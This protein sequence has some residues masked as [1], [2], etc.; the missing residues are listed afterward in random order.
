M[1]LRLVPR[2]FPFPDADPDRRLQILVMVAF[3][4]LFDQLSGRLVGKTFRQPP[5][6]RPLDLNI[7]S[8]PHFISGQDIKDRQLVVFEFL[9]VDW[10]QVLNGDDRNR[11]PDHQENRM[12]GNTEHCTRE[13]SGRSLY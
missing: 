13:R 12:K 11:G 10:I 5:R 2:Q 3:A 1:V 9:L 7:E 6:N 4:D 8:P